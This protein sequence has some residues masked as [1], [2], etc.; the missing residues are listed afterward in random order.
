MDIINRGNTT[1]SPD[2]QVII[3]DKEDLEYTIRSLKKDF[4]HIVILL[5]DEIEEIPVTLNDIAEGVDVEYI[6]LGDLGKSRE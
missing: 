3:K 2:I 5:D 6:H 4:N 1:N